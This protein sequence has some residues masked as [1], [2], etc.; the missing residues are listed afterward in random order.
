MPK[1]IKPKIQPLI[2][3][4]ITSE[5]EFN[6]NNPARQSAIQIIEQIIEP[7]HYPQRGVNGEKYYDLEDRITHI[8]LNNK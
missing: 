6:V 4:K 3:S 1:E 5:D 2:Y 7:L 8:I